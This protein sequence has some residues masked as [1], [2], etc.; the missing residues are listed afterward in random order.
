MHKDKDLSEHD[1]VDL[2]NKEAPTDPHQPPMNSRDNVINNKVT[3]TPSPVASI[4]NE[5]YSL[6]FF[7]RVTIEFSTKKQKNDSGQDYVNCKLCGKYFTEGRKLVDHAMIK[8]E[9]KE[10]IEKK[11]NMIWSDRN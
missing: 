1:L 9:G 3:A 5:K 4:Q 10:I 6:L 11:F 8:H 2:K 7:K